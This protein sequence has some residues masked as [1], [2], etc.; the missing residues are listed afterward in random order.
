MT[1]E[2]VTFTEYGFVGGSG[3]LDGSG[4]LWRCTSS[5]E[6]STVNEADH[7]V[8]PLSDKAAQVYKPLSENS[9][10]T[11]SK[12]RR[13]PLPYLKLSFE[14]CLDSLSENDCTNS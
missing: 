8:S 12:E 5:A 2:L 10:S 14:V 4:D 6:R 11:P 1:D 9:K 13:T 3:S 7:V